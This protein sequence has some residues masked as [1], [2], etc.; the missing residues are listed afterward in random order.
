MSGRARY[1]APPTIA[2][3]SRVYQHGKTQVPAEVREALRLKDGD[4]ILWCEEGSR[5]YVK[6]LE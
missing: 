6:R 1:T 3:V 2:G 4:R 5:I